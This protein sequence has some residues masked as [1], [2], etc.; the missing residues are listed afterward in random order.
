[1]IPKEVDTDFES[2][3]L[4]L[5]KAWYLSLLTLPKTIE[6]FSKSNILTS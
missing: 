2:A 5:Q 1:M 6:F 3:K 4:K